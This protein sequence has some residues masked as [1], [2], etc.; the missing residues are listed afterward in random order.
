MLFALSIR[1]LRSSLLRGVLPP[2]PFLVFILIPT[3]YL[4]APPLTT[5]LTLLFPQL[6]IPC[7]L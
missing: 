6:L 2:S 5:V 7:I 4:L 3:D 1:P